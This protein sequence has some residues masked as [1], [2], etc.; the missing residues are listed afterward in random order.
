MGMGRVIPETLEGRK[1]DGGRLRTW[2]VAW[3]GI[4]LP[5]RFALTSTRSAARVCVNGLGL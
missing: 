3:H 2:G 1:E 5:L 4:A